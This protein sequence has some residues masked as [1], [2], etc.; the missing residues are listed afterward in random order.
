MMWCGSRPVLCCAG[1]AA[2]G[3]GVMQ[4]HQVTL[5]LVTQS[6]EALG[7]SRHTDAPACEAT[8]TQHCYCPFNQP[9]SQHTR[10][11]KQC[12]DCSSRA[13]DSLKQLHALHV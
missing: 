4:A 5:L 3:S 11:K 1:S 12:P 10:A 8:S 6:Q 13:T 2:D 9:L 7:Q